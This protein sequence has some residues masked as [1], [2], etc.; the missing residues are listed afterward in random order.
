MVELSWLDEPP[1]FYELADD[2]S[3]TEFNR[4]VTFISNLKMVSILGIFI[5]LWTSEADPPIFCENLRTHDKP[6]PIF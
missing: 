5:L 2:L 4:Q 3:I 1:K 6:M